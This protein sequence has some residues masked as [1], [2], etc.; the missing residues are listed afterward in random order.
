MPRPRSVEVPFLDQYVL[1][2]SLASRRACCLTP[3]YVRPVAIALKRTPHLD[4]LEGL[5]PDESI[6]SQFFVGEPP[7]DFPESS[8]REDR[9]LGRSRLTVMMGRLEL[10]RGACTRAVQ[11]G[12]ARCTTP[13]TPASQTRRPPGPSTAYADSCP[14]QEV[15][16]LVPPELPSP[17]PTRSRQSLGSGVM[18]HAGSP[19]DSRDRSLDLPAHSL[20]R[21]RR[22][23]RL[24]TSRCAINSWSSSDPFA[25]HAWRSGTES[26][27]LKRR[28]KS[29][30]RWSYQRPL[31]PPRLGGRRPG[32]C[33][34]RWARLVILLFA[35]SV[36]NDDSPAPDRGCDRAAA[37]SGSRLSTSAKKRLAL[38]VHEP[39]LPAEPPTSLPPRAV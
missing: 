8:L 4:W 30:A 3:Q 16:R 12:G 26:S 14:S 37:P 19:H 33:R 9:Q 24:R 25:D 39:R 35:R 11:A 32:V 29:K 23:S 21:F 28:V 18:H 1:A 20:D 10:G 31:S 2:T 17:P 7:P 13:P 38:T 22:P 6:Q 34:A 15:H 5:D 27:S 36:A